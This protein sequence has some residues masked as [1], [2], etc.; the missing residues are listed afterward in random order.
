MSLRFLLVCSEAIAKCALERRESR[1]GH[2]RVDHLE[3]SDEYGQFNHVVKLGADGK[4]E[5]RREPLPQ[6]PPDLKAL[7]ED[8]S[9]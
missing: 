1:G 7:F 2:M 9:K 4:M 6:M 5:L 3:T 8:G